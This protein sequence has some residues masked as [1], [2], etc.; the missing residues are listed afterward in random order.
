MALSFD[1]FQRE[2]VILQLSKIKD[3][4]HDLKEEK[5]ERQKDIRI[6]SRIVKIKY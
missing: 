1:M 6:Y 4:N 5:R 2:E 3:K